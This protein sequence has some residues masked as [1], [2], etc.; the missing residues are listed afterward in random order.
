MEKPP[1][2]DEIPTTRKN[3]M[4][5]S[6]CGC[7][8]KESS[9][10]CKD[11]GQSTKASSDELQPTEPTLPTS[12]HVNPPK[13]VL[14]YATT[15]ILVFVGIIIYWGGSN[16]AEDLHSSGISSPFLNFIDN[17]LIPVTLAVAFLALAI[18]VIYGIY[19][20]SKYYEGTIACG[21]C[22]YI[23]PGKSGRSSWARF[24]VWI[25]FFLG[26][27]LLLSGPLITLLYYLNTNKY[28]CPKCNSTFIGRKNING[29]YSGTKNSSVSLQET[30]Q[31]FLIIALISILTSVVLAFLN[32]EGSTGQNTPIHEAV[33]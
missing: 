7:K 33:L 15:P 29:H 9:L 21:N 25:I 19:T 1:E 4:F 28:V 24:T 12:A 23:G 16:L 5:C 3:V 32:D 14:F 8:N 22:D 13:S 18:G 6:K 20:N 2:I 26:S 31:M 27:P 11:C 30:L 10:L 17:I